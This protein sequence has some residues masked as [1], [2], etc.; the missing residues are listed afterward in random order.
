MG[1]GDRV[2]DVEE[3]KDGEGENEGAGDEA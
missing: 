3:N 2:L 1:D